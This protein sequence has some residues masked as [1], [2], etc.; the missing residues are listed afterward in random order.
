MTYDGLKTAE[1]EGERGTE[2]SSPE[3]TSGDG[4]THT[5]L[6]MGQGED[7]SGVGERN[8]TFTGR[9]ESTEEVDEQGN[10]TSSNIT[11]ALGD[12]GAE[13]SGEKG[14]GHLREGEEKQASATEGINGPE[15]RE[16]EEPVDGTK[17]ERAKSSLE[18]AHTGVD[19]DGGRV[20]SDNVDTAHL[21][22]NHDDESSD[23]GAAYSGNGE[24]LSESSDIVGLG[25]NMFLNGELG[26]NVVEI[27][28]NLDVIV[29]KLGHGLPSISV[30][31]LLHVPT[32]RLGAEVDEDEK[33]DSGEE[34]SAKHESPV[35][36][37]DVENSQVEGS[38]QEDTE[39]GPHLPG[40]D[41]GTSNSGGSVLSSV[42]RDGRSLSTHTNT[43]EDTAG[44]LLLPGLAEGRTDDRPDTEVSREED[45]TATTEVV[46]DR[47]REPATDE[48]ISKLACLSGLKLWRQKVLRRTEIGSSVNDTKNQLIASG[49]LGDTIV[50]GEKDVGTV[51]TSLIPTLDGS[52]NG[53]SCDGEDQLPGHGPPVVG[54]AV[55]N[56][57]LTVS[58][59]L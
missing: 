7:L 28:G 32:R 47:V 14:P 13:T 35:D 8:G 43:H 52:T 46:V 18:L 11:S 25:H 2:D 6:T 21:L 36:S 19:E 37:R 30:A 20:E 33:R 38:S 59:G 15:G 5:S 24:K 22:G 12:Q 26:T 53:A 56:S 40:H 50:F 9:V 39:G 54:L 51:G 27:A 49:L 44:K 42:D 17:A 41:Q 23:S 45:D 57:D 16:G 1:Q 34:G 58:E 10:K 55:K 48:T 3:E 4:E 31:T 29:S